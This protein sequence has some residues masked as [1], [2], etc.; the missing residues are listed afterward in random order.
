MKAHFNIKTLLFIV[1]IFFFNAQFSFAA[2]LL[3]GKVTDINN[4]PIEFANVIV[5]NAHNNELV[6]GEVQFENWSVQGNANNTV[7]INCFD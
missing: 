5:T 1:I 2:Q 7:T 3:T 4:A 6:K